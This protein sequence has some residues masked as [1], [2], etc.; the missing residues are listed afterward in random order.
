MVNL[1]APMFLQDRYKPHFTNIETESDIK[2]N[3]WDFIDLSMVFLSL[4]AASKIH[5]REKK[6]VTQNRCY[7]FP[8]DR[9]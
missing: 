4:K 1:I 5:I 6:L 9:D 3:F 2:S 7:Y 8:S